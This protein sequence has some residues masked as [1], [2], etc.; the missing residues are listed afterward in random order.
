MPSH[1]EKSLLVEGS[2]LSGTDVGKGGFGGFGGVR[3]PLGLP[4]QC[5]RGL[6]VRSLV[7]CHSGRACPFISRAYRNGSFIYFHDEYTNF[8]LKFHPEQCLRV[9]VCLCSS[10]TIAFAHFHFRFRSVPSSCGRRFLSLAA[11]GSHGK[12]P[13]P[14]TP[15]FQPTRPSP[16]LP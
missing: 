14:R 5:F 8:P 12:Q 15:T 1:A 2:S 7:G 11:F 16:W 4:L 6:V 13:W 3:A 10:V 9:S